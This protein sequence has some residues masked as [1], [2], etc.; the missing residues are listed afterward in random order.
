M[1]H[2]IFKDHLKED[3]HPGMTKYVIL[4]ADAQ[5]QI[6]GFQMFVLHFYFQQ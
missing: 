5:M 3:L 6:S 1:T 4:F 2:I